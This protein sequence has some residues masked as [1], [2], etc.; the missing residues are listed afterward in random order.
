MMLLHPKDN[1]LPSLVHFF[2]LFVIIIQQILCVTSFDE[3][4]H[5][6]ECQM[7]AKLE[8]RTLPLQ[9]QGQ[10]KCSV[11]EEC[12]GFMCKGKYQVM[13]NVGICHQT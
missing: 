1:S 8:N 12:T 3:K 11:N 2:V 10:A 7:W 13:K 9:N 4:R 6:A 5:R